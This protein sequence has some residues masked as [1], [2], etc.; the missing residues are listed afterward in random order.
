MLHTHALRQLS[1]MLQTTALFRRLIT[2]HTCTHPNNEDTVHNQSQ[3]SKAQQGRAPLEQLTQPRTGPHSTKEQRHQE[4]CSAGSY[5]SNCGIGI[6]V[7]SLAE[8]GSS[9]S[10]HSDGQGAEARVGWQEALH[11]IAAAADQAR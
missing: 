6:R 4:P 11:C 7:H 1:L 8:G 5:N 2:T 3:Q 10:S 9:S